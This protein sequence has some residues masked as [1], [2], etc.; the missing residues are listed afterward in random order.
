MKKIIATIFLL[1]FALSAC[2][3]AGGDNSDIANPDEG[4]EIVVY[5]SPT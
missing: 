3:S 5:R 1:V 4:V 2:S